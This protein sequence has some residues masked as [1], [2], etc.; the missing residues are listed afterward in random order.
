MQCGYLQGITVIIL[1]LNY[2]NFIFSGRDFLLNYVQRLC[3]KKQLSKLKKLKIC[4]QTEFMNASELFT[5]LKN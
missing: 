5:F 4:K 3:A 2:K 1:I